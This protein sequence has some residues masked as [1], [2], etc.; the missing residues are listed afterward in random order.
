MDFIQ[1]LSP[2]ESKSLW[3]PL[4]LRYTSGSNSKEEKFEFDF[5]LDSETFHNIVQQ[6]SRFSYMNHL[7]I[8]IEI[9]FKN[10]VFEHKKNNQPTPMIWDFIKTVSPSL[11]LVMTRKMKAKKENIDDKERIHK[12]VL[13]EFFK[14]RINKQIDLVISTGNDYAENKRTYSSKLERL[15]KSSLFV[16]RFDLP[17][18]DK[19]NELVRFRIAKN[20]IIEFNTTIL[21]F[22]L[23]VK[24]PSYIILRKTH[25]TYII[26]ELKNVNIVKVICNII[27]GYCRLYTI[28]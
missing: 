27:A 7:Q 18:N 23:E 26:Q 16:W 10:F 4:F 2:T 17:N 3:D 12:S 25:E 28:N 15:T 21:E 24:M 9:T 13:I 1:G 19:N 5:N 6:R 20:K 22:P 8:L 11:F 14:S